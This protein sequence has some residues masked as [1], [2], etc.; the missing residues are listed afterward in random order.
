MAPGMMPIVSLQ[1]MLP[2]LLFSVTL[3][4]IH[5]FPNKKTALKVAVKA[6]RERRNLDQV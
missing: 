1:V 2:P 3:F 5:Q 6:I 4:L